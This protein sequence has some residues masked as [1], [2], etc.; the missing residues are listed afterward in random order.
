MLI[1]C[2]ETHSLQVSGMLTTSASDAQDSYMAPSFNEGSACPL[3]CLP[4]RY[5]RPVQTGCDRGA[6]H[7]EQ[8]GQVGGGGT[9]QIASREVPDANSA[10]SA[11]DRV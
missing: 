1:R 2:L 5:A 6:V 8:L 3:R 9:G 10:K 11:L 4:S 7:S